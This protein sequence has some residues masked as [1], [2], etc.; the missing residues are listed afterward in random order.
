MKRWWNTMA[1]IVALVAFGCGGAKVDKRGTAAPEWA[2]NPPKG[3]GTGSAK[4]RGLRDIA[5]DGAVTSARADLARDLKT[6]MQGMIKKYQASGETGGADFTEELTTGVTR[7]IVDQT[8]IGTRVVR[9]EVLEG[10]LFALVCLD[11]ETF[12][13]AFERMSQLSQAQRVALKAR[14][15]AEFKD[16]DQ[17]IEKLR[18]RDQ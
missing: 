11:P 8:L 12:K 7:D 13:D 18:A 14:A 1:G 4:F 17:Q 5:R 16:L 3:C 15:D 6:T 2:D 10:E 9:T